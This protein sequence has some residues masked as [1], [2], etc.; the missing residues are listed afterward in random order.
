MQYI[1]RELERKF[2]RMNG[3]FKA[4]LVTGARQVGKTTMLR[5]LAEGGNRTYISLDDFSA[6]DLAQRDPKLFFQTYKPPILIDEIQ[7][8]PELFE[9][10]KLLCDES[11]E[12]GLFWLTGSQQYRM[13]RHAG[14]TL[15]GRIEI[16][17]LYSFSQREKQELFL[18]TNW[19]LRWKVCK[20]GSGCSLK[21][22]FIPF[23]AISGRAV[24]RSCS[25]Q[26][27]NC[28]ANI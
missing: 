10:M 22:T 6:R 13:M 12:T 27:K 1:P 7:K 9:Q 2:I 19:T 8:A 25:A 28:G 11:E 14:E 4:I 20:H 15:A 16:L 17:E 26:T 23:S 21:T 24:C 3:F 18:T 5:H